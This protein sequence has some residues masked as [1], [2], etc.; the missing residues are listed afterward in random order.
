[1]P[2]SDGREAE[3]GGAGVGGAASPVIP[4]TAGSPAPVPAEPSTFPAVEDFD[5]DGPF[6]PM[7]EAAGLTCTIFRPRTL[8]EEGRRHP[9]LVWGNGT[10]NTPSSYTSFLMHLASHGFIVTAA[11]TSNAGSGREMLDCLDDIVA[12]DKAEGPYRGAVDFMRVL[13]TGY[14]Q[15][16]AGSMMAARDPRFLATGLISPFTVLPLGGFAISSVDEQ[17][18]PMLMISG[19][20]DA[21]AS[22]DAHQRPIFMQAKVP[23]V[24][25]TLSGASHLEVLGTG[26]RYRGV[27]TAWYR[28]R[29]MDD[30]QAAELFSKDTCTLCE[31]AG[32]RVEWN[33]LWKD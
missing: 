19:S 9:V 29:L 22:P 3:L 14:S 32:W 26:G 12:R 10:F 4:A 18:H 31:R 2:A 5:R 28:A 1:M 13:A 24:W 25:A 11:N 17:I 6:T 7:S 15:G 8:G 20:V 21:V 27:M 23:I 30:P 33:G 16:G